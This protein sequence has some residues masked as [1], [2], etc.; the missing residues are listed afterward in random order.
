[1]Q[2]ILEIILKLLE[3]FFNRSDT[4]R[5]KEVESELERLQ[6]KLNEA[7]EQKNKSAIIYYNN[8]ISV[9]L[10]KHPNS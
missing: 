8:L 3:L 2:K 1:M 7:I 6:K 10:R 5:E 9:W 4:K